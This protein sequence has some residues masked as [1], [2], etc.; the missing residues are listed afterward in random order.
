MNGLDRC[1]RQ[2]LQGT[3]KPD[4]THWVRTYGSEIE[5]R[6]SSIRKELEDVEALRV[7]PEDRADD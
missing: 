2:A 5:S 4:L 1:I 6:F 3:V 7:R